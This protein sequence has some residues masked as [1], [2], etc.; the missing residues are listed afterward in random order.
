MLPA[1]SSADADMLAEEFDFSG[2]EIENVIRKHSIDS[3]LSST[4][5]GSFPHLLEACRHERIT[6]S[7][8]RLGF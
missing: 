6:S 5:M 7:R 4:P 2:G 3:I 1:I 8:P